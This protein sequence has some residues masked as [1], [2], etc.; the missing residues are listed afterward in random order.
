MKAN[1]LFQLQGHNA[2]IVTYGEQ[3]DISNIC[4]F[5]WYKCLYEKDGSEPF[6]CMTDILGRCLGPAKNE[7]NKK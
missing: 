2:H 7:G 6:P 3:L 1:N 4:P 5:G